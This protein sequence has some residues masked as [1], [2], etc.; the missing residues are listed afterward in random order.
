MLVFVDESEWPR[1]KSPGGYTVWGAAALHPSKSKSFV[2]DVFNLEKKFW[3]INEP[4]EF[5]IKGRLL[6]NERSVLT[7]PKKCEFCEE[8]ISL[9]KL[10]GVRAFA[11][12]LRNTNNEALTGLTEPII[13]KAYSLLLERVEAMMQEEFNDD[14][15]VIALDSAEEATDTNRALAFGNYVYGSP[16]GRA[17]VHVVETPFF[18]SSKA[19]VGIQIADLIAYALAQ[20]NLGRTYIRD[21]CDRIRELEWK[22]Q[23][24]DT[25]YPLHGSRFLDI[26][27]PQANAQG[28]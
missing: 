24:T 1:P 14:M 26:E 2:R 17:A 23:R 11:I 22:S 10:A 6:L 7:S 21:I 13:Y 27:R 15:A 28:L 18:V 5:E 16:T 19:T 25:E 4:Y 20:R 8:I 12:G 9:C 3:K